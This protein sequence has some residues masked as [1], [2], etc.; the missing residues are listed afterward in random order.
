MLRLSVK[1]PKFVGSKRRYVLSAIVSATQGKQLAG[2]FRWF[3][4]SHLGDLGVKQVWAARAT[5]Q[6]PDDA[7]LTF[8]QRGVPLDPGNGDLKAIVS[9]LHA[10][11]R[12]GPLQAHVERKEVFPFGQRG[13]AVFWVDPQENVKMDPDLAE[14][15]RETLENCGWLKIPGVIGW[16]RGFYTVDPMQVAPLRKYMSAEVLAAWTEATDAAKAA[17]AISAGVL[18]KDATRTIIA[19]AGVSADAPG[20]LAGYQAFG[21]L[22][23]A[24]SD[25][26]MIADEMGLGK[27]CQAIM[28]ARLRGAKDI[29]VIAQANNK[30]NW[31]REWFAWTG[32]VG[33]YIGVADGDVLPKT[34]IVVIN[35]DILGRHQEELAR[36]RFDYLIVD[37]LQNFCNPESKRTQALAGPAPTY[38][39]VQFGLQGLL[40]S[41]RAFCFLS[42]TPTPNGPR[43]FWPI[44]RIIDPVRW[45]TRKQDQTAFEDRYCD[46]VYFQA[47]TPYGKRTVRSITKNDRRLDEMR[48]AL[49]ST[50]MIRRVKTDP[51]VAADLPPKRRTIY[52]I[53][54]RLTREIVDVLAHLKEDSDRSPEVMSSLRAAMLTAYEGENEEHD[55]VVVTNDTTRAGYD[56]AARLERFDGRIELQDRSRILANYARLKAPIVAESIADDLIDTDDKIMVFCKHLD[57]L[58]AV[59]AVLNKR[60]A[61]RDVDRANGPRRVVVYHGGMGMNARQAVVDGF[62]ENPDIKVIVGTMAM[63]TGIKLTAACRVEM[64]EFDDRPDQMLQIEDRPYRYGQ[65]ASLLVRFWPAAG[66]PEVG[67]AQ[68]LVTKIKRLEKSLGSKLSHEVMLDALESDPARGHEAR[69]PS[70]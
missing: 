10:R 24:E 22:K 11:D 31:K 60:F 44:G 54:I 47:Q 1:E 5:L 53:P 64:V 36:R 17:K 43:N 23:A 32:E 67:I 13:R 16:R 55:H 58:K 35:Q 9:S 49:E 70:P 8:L 20:V 21:A 48:V 65:K 56:D 42:G 34:P 26:I 51:Q 33:D 39:E 18:D 14:A 3:D 52:E 28:A 37:E 59:E 50:V 61:E 38:D 7:I 30:I 25:Q 69:A 57:A 12:S 2:L 6:R 41:S 45:G 62:Q 27:T 19:R 63:A 46:P 29:L 66:S 4:M 40:G 15:R 68:N